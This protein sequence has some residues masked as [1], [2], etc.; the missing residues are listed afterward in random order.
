MHQVDQVEENNL[1]NLC[2]IRNGK[3]KSNLELEECRGA[4]QSNL[5]R[6]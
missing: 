5:D 3:G 1:N 4:G 2:I 6:Q